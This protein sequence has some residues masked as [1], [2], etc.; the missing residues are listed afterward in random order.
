MIRKRKFKI[1]FKRKEELLSSDH[2]TVERYSKITKKNQNA[3][4]E[5]MVVK[6]WSWVRN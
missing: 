1:C 5:W 4:K 6:C 3:D 2:Q